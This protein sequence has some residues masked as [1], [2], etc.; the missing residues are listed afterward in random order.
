MTTPLAPGVSVI[1]KSSGTHLI[2]GVGTSTAAFVATGVDGDPQQ[3]QSWNSF[4]AV[5]LDPKATTKVSAAVQEAVYGFFANGGTECW[6]V[7]DGTDTGG[8]AP[9]RLALLDVSIVAAPDLT[10]AVAYQTLVTHCATMRN[11][12][13]IVT[14]PDDTYTPSEPVAPVLGA[15]KNYAAVYYPYLKGP[16]ST[17]TS[18][19][20]SPCGYIAGVWARVDAQRGVFKAPANEV[21]NGV[22]A[23]TQTLSDTTLASFYGVGVNCLRVFPGTGPLVWGARTAAASSDSDNV[24]LNVRR[25]LCFLEESIRRAT[26][27]AVFEPNDDR[28]WASLRGTVG[29]FLT[30]QWR[31]GA[32]MGQTPT[33]AFAITCDSTNNTPAIINAGQVVCDIAVAPVRPAEYVTFTVTQQNPATPATAG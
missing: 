24:Y 31:Q 1:E 2:T 13:M 11:R 12:V 27:W 29:T 16:G 26:T 32:L 3:L 14:L 33:Q 7:P 20:I 25:L 28:L 19:T 17:G 4:G 18:Q 6:V 15:G 9:D 8:K 5:Y 23:L 10:T 22:T 30:E 21:L